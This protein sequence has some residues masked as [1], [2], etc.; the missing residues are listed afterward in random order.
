MNI[1]I[2]GRGRIDAASS[3]SSDHRLWSV[4]A[5]GDGQFLEQDKEEVVLG[6]IGTEVKEHFNNLREKYAL[7]RSADST[8]LLALEAAQQAVNQANWSMEEF[9]LLV[10]CSRGPTTS[11]EHYWEQFR[12]TGRTRSMASPVTTLGSVTNT[13]ANFFGQ[14]GLAIGQSVTCS[15]G[16]HAI[17]QAVA[18]LQS[19][20][21]DRVLVGGTEA[22][23]TPFTI[24]QMKAMRI[25]AKAHS[26][27]LAS[28]PGGMAIGEGAAMFCL[29]QQGEGFFPKLLGIG[30]AR[31]N[32]HSMAGISADGTALRMAMEK[33]M[34]EAGRQPDLIIPHAPGTKAGDAAEMAALQRLFGSDIPPI[35]SGKWATGHTFGASGPLALDLALE[36]L[37]ERK[38]PVMPYE[39]RADLRTW[40]EGDPLKTILV[41]ATG[42]GGNAV[43][44]LVG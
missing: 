4:Y 38:V 30:F 32:A 18:L 40:K 43:S 29:S 37:A 16:F 8:A 21:V 27:P 14:A 20:L 44:I 6:R 9:A 28:E 11:W 19:G 31:E 26:W 13:L 41:N 42:F 23:L 36:L 15:S 1:S 7:L 17:V 39:L 12:E 22:P 5:S 34:Q 33:A 3:R 24:A 25:T 2:V 10:G 35:Y